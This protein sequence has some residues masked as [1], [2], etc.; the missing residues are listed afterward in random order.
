M[1]NSLFTLSAGSSV[2]V[3]GYVDADSATYR[4]T[5]ADN[6]T[7]AS[8]TL[9]DNPDTSLPDGYT[10]PAYTTTAPSGTTETPSS[11]TDVNLSGAASW[12]LGRW[13]G[14]NNGYGDDCTDFVS[15]AIHFGGGDQEDY[16]WTAPENYRDDHYWYRSTWY[17]VTVATYSWAGAYHFADHLVLRGN[18]KRMYWSYSTPG[19]VIFANW[20]GSSFKGIS[21]TGIITKMSNG[22]P[23]ITQHTNDK[24]NEPL[25][26]WLNSGSNVNV[27]VFIP[28]PG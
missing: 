11:S 8:A 2:Q 28:D 24:K 9:N 1:T 7:A 13:N 27:W 26:D 15:R 3:T 23:M 21:H 12:A 4:A 18:Y 19:D 6:T 14:T 22:W 17:G 20:S 16:G 10:A 5:G 25:W